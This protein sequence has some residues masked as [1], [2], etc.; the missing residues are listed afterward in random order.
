MAHPSLHASYEVQ[1]EKLLASASLQLT[2]EWALD[3]MF[4][5]RGLTWLTPELTW[6]SKIRKQAALLYA[7]LKC[8]SNSLASKI[9]N[10]YEG[11]GEAIPFLQHGKDL[12]CE[13]GVSMEMPKGKKRKSQWK[14]KLSEHLKQAEQQK[15]QVQIDA[16]EGASD[17]LMLKTLPTAK[18]TIMHWDELLPN[19]NDQALVHQLKLGAL[20]WT[21]VARSRQDKSFPALPQLWKTTLLKCPCHIESQST[22]HI[23]KKC[24]IAQKA[25]ASN[26][27]SV[28]DFPKGTRSFSSAPHP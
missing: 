25:L 20:K 1:W 28:N 9:M 15:L 13:A 4:K 8:Q 18:G 16:A 26:F 11:N 17:E 2:G 5:H 27:S 6:E 19:I 14:K 3:P 22:T 10:K 21:L 7:K 23:W 24:P 12:L